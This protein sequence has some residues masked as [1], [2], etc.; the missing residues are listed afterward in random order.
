MQH[1]TKCKTIL[2]IAMVVLWGMAGA[3]TLPTSEVEVACQNVKGIDAHKKCVMTYG[4]MDLRS[5]T[6]AVEIAGKPFTLD[7]EDGGS[8]K[9]ASAEGVTV[10]IMAQPSLHDG[11]LNGLLIVSDEKV[12]P[13]EKGWFGPP[14]PVV[15]K[16]DLPLIVTT[17]T[18][19]RVT[20]IVRD[21]QS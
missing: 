2:A 14:A 10:Q 20:M 1:Q 4:S 9:L 19:K 3:H 12:G 5:Y 11:V 18:G 7:L 13:G 6:V 16:R 17:P 8:P 21:I 15:I